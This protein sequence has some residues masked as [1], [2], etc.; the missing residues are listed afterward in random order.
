MSY[1]QPSAYYLQP[2]ASPLV[3]R[4][5]DTALSMRWDGFDSHTGC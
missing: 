1:L 4:F 3:Y 2:N 5:E